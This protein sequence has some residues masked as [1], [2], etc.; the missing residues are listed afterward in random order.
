MSSDPTGETW[1]YNPSPG[2]W[3]HD[4]PPRADEAL[5][6]AAQCASAAA[7]NLLPADAAIA[8]AA[9]AKA[10]AAIAAVAPAQGPAPV[11]YSL[12]GSDAG[13]EGTHLGGCTWPAEQCIGH[14]P[15]DKVWVP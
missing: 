4:R 10:W 1:R 6:M 2:Q 15:E 13:P 3:T 12:F 5:L 7:D 9:A 8:R 14:V 11:K